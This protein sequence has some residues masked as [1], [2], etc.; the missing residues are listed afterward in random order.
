MNLGAFLSGILDKKALISR[1]IYCSFYGD[2]LAG[3][4]TCAFN[5]VSELLINKPFSKTL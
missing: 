5:S 3:N 4:T 2:D 1:F